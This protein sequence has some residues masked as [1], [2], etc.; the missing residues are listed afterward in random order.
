LFVISGI[1]GLIATIWAR[2]APGFWWSLISAFIGIVAGLALFASP[3][4]RAL[5]LVAFFI[6]E[7]VAS[8]MYAIDHRRQLIRRTFIVHYGWVW[9]LLSGIIGIILAP[10]IFLG[11]PTEVAV[12]LLLGIYILFDGGALIA[13]ALVARQY[14]AS[15]RR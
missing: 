3:V 5:V 6:I 13:I 8:I 1:V 14:N 4:T 10:I 9:K 7:G 11:K 12:V 15:V 2:H